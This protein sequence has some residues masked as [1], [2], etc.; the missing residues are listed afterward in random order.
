MDLSSTAILEIKVKEVTSTM[1]RL[2][3]LSVVSPRSDMMHQSF[4]KVNATS[5]SKITSQEMR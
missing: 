2:V 1:D 4:Q 5:A 3:P